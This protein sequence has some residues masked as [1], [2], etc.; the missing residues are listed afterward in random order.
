MTEADDEALDRRAKAIFEAT[1]QCW[2][3]L[4][5]LEPTDKAMAL[6]KLDDMLAMEAASM[7][8]AYALERRH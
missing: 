7:D 5:D 8:P 3:V 4:S 1:R 2:R 6:S